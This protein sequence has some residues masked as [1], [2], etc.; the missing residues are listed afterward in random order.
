VKVAHQL[1][2]NL[3]RAKIITVFNQKGGSG[4]TTLSMNLG[5]TAARRG[6]KTLICDMDTQGTASDWAANSSE[7]LEQFP[8][9]VFSLSKMG[10]K[11]SA[12]IQKYVG[13]Y[14]LII[15]DCPPS[16]ESMVPRVSMIISDLALIPIM[17]SPSDILACARAKDLVKD[18]MVLN[19]TLVARTILMQYQPTN[20]C[21]DMFKVLKDDQEIPP[22]ESYTA[23]RT[24]YKEAI[25]RGSTVH[26][27]VHDKKAQEEVET[28]TTEVLSLLGY[29]ELSPVK[30]GAENE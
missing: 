21:E 12:E 5:G 13:D 30:V 20:L 16:L 11:F 2:T 19:T 6:L 29:E 23:L 22:L 15:V 8:C 27:V 1:K 3:M 4:K 7:G 26:G 24:S 18:V 28:I 10:G 14:D 9:S 25:I 17:P